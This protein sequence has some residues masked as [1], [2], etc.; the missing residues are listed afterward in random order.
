MSNLPKV[1]TLCNDC[2]AEID[3]EPMDME[4]MEFE[5]VP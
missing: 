5:F 3:E 2:E 1:A 4:M